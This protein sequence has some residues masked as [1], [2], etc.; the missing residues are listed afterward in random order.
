[1]WWL[2]ETRLWV[3]STQCDIHMVTEYTRSVQ[4]VSSHA[5][6]EIE[7]F[8]EEDTRYRKHCTQDNDGS[9]LF[10]VGYLDLTQFSQLPSATPCYFPESHWWSE[11]SSLSKV[12]LVFGKDR[13]RRVLN[14][15]CSRGRVTRV[16]WCFT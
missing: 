2:K 5:I 13:G 6:W 9:V 7:T 11:I 16:I 1:M 12:I 3:V 8:T 15:G 10:K 4:K 14:L